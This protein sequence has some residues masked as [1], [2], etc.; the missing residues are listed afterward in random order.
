MSP[1]VTTVIERVTIINLFRDAATTN[2]KSNKEL[3]YKNSFNSFRLLN[4]FWQNLKFLQHS[5]SS[6]QEVFSKKDVLRN[7]ANLKHLCQSLFFN[8]VAGL[9]PEGCNFIK[10]G[11][12]TQVFSCEFWKISK[13]TFLT[14]HL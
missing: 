11:T 10:K 7:F 9:K 5:R 4:T 3:F 2:Q 12:M 6:C 1:P 8:K 14:E 13:N